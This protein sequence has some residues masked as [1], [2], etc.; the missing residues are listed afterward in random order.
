MADMLQ[1]QYSSVFSTPSPQSDPVET[2]EHENTPVIE[3]ITFSQEDIISAIKEIGT[4]SSSAESDIPAVVLKQC[5]E[6]LSY[7]ILLIWRDSLESGVVPKNFKKQ[8]ITPVFKKGSRAKASNYRPI[9]LTSHLIKIF[10]RVLR[11]HI[12]KHLEENNLLCSNQHGFRKGRSCLTQL[13]KHVDRILNNFLNG[14]DTDCIYLDFAKAFDK[15]DH[16]ILLAKLHSYGIRGKLLNWFKSYLAD[17]DQTVVVKGS[18]SYPS[19]VQSGVPQGTVLGPI[20]FLIYINDLAK[21]INHSIVSHFADD[22]RISKAIT[23]ISDVTELQEDL[24]ETIKWSE[25]NKMKLHTDKFELLCHSSKKQNLLQQLPFSCQFFEYTTTD[26]ITITP[27]D[28]VR[29]LGAN[30]TP[31]ISWSPHINIMVNTARQMTS[32]VLSVF[33]DRS[34]KTMM[35]LYKSIIR[36][37]LEYL[38]P[39]WNPSKQEDI[40]CIESVQRHFTSKIKDLSEFSYHDR[41]KILGLMSLQRRRERFIIITVW[42][43]INKVMPNDLDLIITKNERRGIKVKVP[44]LRRDSTQHAQSCY[45]T[46]FAVVGA[47]LWDTLPRGVSTIT[48][49]TTFKTVLTRYLSQI[50][51]LPP[52]D[53][54]SSRNSLLDLN[55]LDLQGGCT[56]EDGS[57]DDLHL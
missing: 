4:H 37:R 18:H 10:E 28:M 38:S 47:K 19:K 15:V 25:N 24:I 32:W 21:C 3:D 57:C 8:I 55:R 2:T 43:I 27:C 34:E 48:N 35:C 42:K 44:P 14:H 13:L 54:Y 39:L 23:G 29:D 30:V 46:S 45:E 22:T 31:S 17:R 52:V 7:P 50:P 26:D 11:K 56:P 40:K 33:K 9:S 6:V 49:K 1:E 53:G 5:A 41:L 20:L 12:V 36:S 51:D 16:Q